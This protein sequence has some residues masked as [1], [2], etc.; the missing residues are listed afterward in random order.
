VKASHRDV[1]EGAD[2]KMDRDRNSSNHQ[3]SREESHCGQENPLTPSLGEVFL[4]ESP[5]FAV[6][7]KKSERAENGGDVKRK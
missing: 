3:N 6:R 2:I 5:K 4:I 1:V 7:D